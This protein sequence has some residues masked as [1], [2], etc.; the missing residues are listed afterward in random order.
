M[1]TPHPPVI[2]PVMAYPVFRDAILKELE[3]RF[4]TP[5]QPVVVLTFGLIGLDGDTIDQE[6]NREYRMND[7]SEVSDLAIDLRIIGFESPFDFDHLERF[8]VEI[9]HAGFLVELAVHKPWGPVERNKVRLVR[10]Y[11]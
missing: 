10:V 4:V 6:V 3:V 1:I 7:T 11:S 2:T 9:E 8:A 5:H